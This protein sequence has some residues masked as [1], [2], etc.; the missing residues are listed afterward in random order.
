MRRGLGSSGRSDTLG[1]MHFRERLRL[2]GGRPK[3]P[4]SVLARLG[5]VRR[6]TTGTRLGTDAP[7]HLA[8]GRP[9]AGRGG[10]WAEVGVGARMR[11]LALVM[12][13]VGLPVF[14]ADSPVR[15]GNEVLVAENFRVLA[16]KRVGLLT[17]PTGVNRQGRSTIEVLRGARGVKL[18]ALFA[19]EHGLRGDLPAGREFTNGVD[20]ASGLPLFSLYGPGPVRKPTSAM[21][22]GIDALVYDL[23][24]TGVRSYTYIS[25][26]GQAMEA[27][28]GAEVE[29]V[30][31]DRPNPLGGL[32]V[33]GPMLN[34]RFRS[35]VGRWEVPYVY[36]LTCGELARMIN[37]EG[38]I[39][40]ACK[41]TVVPLKGWK[42]DM[43]WRDTGLPWVATSPNVPRADSVLYLVATGMLGE[44][45]GVTISMGRDMP[46]QCVAAPWLDAERACAQLNGYGLPG[47][48]F[49]PVHFTAGGGGYRGKRV[50]GAQIRVTDPAAA[51]LVAINFYSLEMARK[52]GGRD[53]FA[54]AVKAGRRFD[55]FDKVNGTDQTRRALQA[56]KSAKE[57]VA[58]W[59]PGEE[60]FRARRR[61]YLLY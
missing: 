45:G 18:V 2:G 61:P 29:V 17:N 57:I 47:L 24:D 20:Q 21:L 25:T 30:V 35:F 56:G 6:M 42:R 41:L 26:L 59:K 34:P 37:G 40:N 36:G 19:P 3:K 7:E 52:V 46:F 39:T 60:A 12:G 38:W 51:P 48:K 32:R 13:L 43:T 49:E 4:R 22:K 27:C 28:G 8:H 31:L 11:F 23:Q 15:L 44:I 5:N 10:G 16:G 55:M 58:A 33:E 9:V 14:G 53:L 54:E 1:K 50:A